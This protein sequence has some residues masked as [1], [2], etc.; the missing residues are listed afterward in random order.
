MNWVCEWR[1]SSKE[2]YLRQLRFLGLHNQEKE[3]GKFDA[4]RTDWK[5]K[6]QRKAMHNLPGEFEW[7]DGRAGFGRD[8]TQNRS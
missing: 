4:H 2:K 1:W 3:L 6:G 5:Y 8:G 7:M